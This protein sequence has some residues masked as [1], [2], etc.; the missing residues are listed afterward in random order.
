MMVIPLDS[1]INLHRMF[2]NIKAL[3]ESAVKKLVTDDYIFLD[4]PYYP[5]VG[6]VMIWEATLQLLKDIQYHCLYSCSVETYRKPHINKSTILLFSSGGNFGDLW[7]KHQRFR[8]KVMA[9]FPENPVVQLPQSVWFEDKSKMHDDIQCYQNHKAQITICLRDQQSFNIISK[10][11]PNVKPLLLPDIALAL[12]INMVMRRNN[13]HSKED[14]GVLYFKRDDKEFVDCHLSIRCDAKGDWPCISQMISS[15]LKYKNLM[16]RLKRV[17]IPEQVRLKVTDWYY[18]YIIK[19][20]Y[21]CNGIHFLMPYHTIYASRLH[22][23][24]LGVLLGKHV[25]MLDNCYHKCSGVYNL[26]MKDIANIKLI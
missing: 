15:V 14:L 9:D 19:D 17:R 6:D 3:L 23:A 8:H 2:D 26:W 13:I 22:A 4:L 7:E 25:I 16:A 20:A 12:D 10:N 24:I 21:L 18:F 5:N 11:Y 1:H